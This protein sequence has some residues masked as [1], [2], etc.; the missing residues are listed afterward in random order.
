LTEEGATGKAAAVDS[1]TFVRGPFPIMSFLNFSSDHYTRVILFTSPLGLTQPDASKLTVTAGGVA[2][3]TPLTVE[4]VGTVTGVTG[5][6][7]S[8]IVV[9][10]SSNLPSGG[11]FPLTVTLFGVPSSNHPTLGISP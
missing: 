3:A 8:Y 1:V 10:L 2:G 4:A 11:D 6:S 7:A 9:K 5:L